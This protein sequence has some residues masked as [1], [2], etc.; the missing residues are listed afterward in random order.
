MH[1]TATHG[2]SFKRRK[3]RR[4]AL[5]ASV[6]AAALLAGGT[7]TGA[8]AATGPVGVISDT[9]K[10]QTLASPISGK[11]EVGFTFSPTA[12]GQL[13][14]VQFYQNATNSGVTSASVWSSTGKRLAQVAVNPN[15]PVGWRTV[16]VDVRLEAGESYTVSVYDSNGRFPRTANFF[17]SAKTT[18]GIYTDASAGVYRVGAGYPTTGQVDSALVDIVYTADEVAPRPAVT[19]TQAPTASPTPT[20]TRTASPTVP[21][22][23]KDIL[24]P[25]GTHWPANTPRAD[26]A[27][28]VNVQ[29]TWAAISAA[30]KAEAKTT[31]A[32]AICVAPGTL[33]GGY[34]AGSTTAGVLSNVGNADRPSR[35]LV[36]ACAGNG[37]VKTAS[38][39][40]VA[41]VGVKGVSFVGIDFS[42]KSVMLRNV[43]NFGFGYT[44]VP[45]LLITANSGNGVKDVD[46]VEVVAG[47][48]AVE[49]AGYDR[50][51]VKSSGGYDVDRLTFSGL[52]AA[53]HYKAAGTSSH[54][55]TIQF[56]TT[57]GTGKINDVV[58]EDSAIFQSSSQG[59]IA[60]HNT[61][62]EIRNTAV[63][64]GKTS[65]LRYPVYA[66]GAAVNLANSL[67]G[68][69]E[70]LKVA[71]TTVA[72]S[73]SAVYTFTDV[74]NSKSTKGERGFAPLGQLTE[75]DLDRMAPIPTDARLATIWR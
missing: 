27:R 49:G 29:P 55:D 58:I 52:Y 10:P 31:D 5:V 32:V 12:S 4:V 40:G 23:S 48:E 66:G 72:G 73:V 1:P 11:F 69:W 34:G 57:S 56:V 18:N 53:P 39:K 62:G 2:A 45:T 22:T 20:P 14:G 68:T 24:G 75:G 36:S 28:V 26:K 44:K 74:T 61:G 42:A 54:T 21:S 7:A 71:D 38:T 47:S 3:R 67:H 15:A 17:A 35:I 50:M 70:G 65:Q 37:T 30:I 8:S 13:S 64:G 6:V 41:L 63:I 19:P 9:A 60:G 46:I 51:E 33:T 59:I 16:P 43:E 25:D